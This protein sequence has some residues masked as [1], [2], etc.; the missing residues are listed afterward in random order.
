MIAFLFYFLVV[1][2]LFILFEAC[3]S[4]I[5]RW[6]LARWHKAPVR[7]AAFFRRIQD[8]KPVGLRPLLFLLWVA[9]LSL[10]VMSYEF[11]R[12]SFGSEGKMWM[13]RMSSQPGHKTNY[14]VLQELPW[15]GK[16]HDVSCYDNVVSE[17]V[18]IG[19]VHETSVFYV[20][21]AALFREY[22][23]TLE[24]RGQSWLDYLLDINNAQPANNPFRLHD[25]ILVANNFA[26]VLQQADVPIDDVPSLAV[27]LCGNWLESQEIDSV[28]VR[29]VSAERVAN[30]ERTVTV[31]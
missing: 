1:T 21:D 29:L 2:V 20:K 24:V 28:Q 31:K 16:F 22:K 27:E 23:I 17:R 11:P 13:I 8:D 19:P 7:V 9:V 15:Y 26:C 3:A 12:I 14:G 25:H 4:D 5:A 18:P 10:S 30:P 6:A